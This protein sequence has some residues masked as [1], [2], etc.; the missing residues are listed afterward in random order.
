MIGFCCDK[1]E[2]VDYLWV[3]FV[4]VVNGGCFVVYGVFI[5]ENCFVGMMYVVNDCV[6]NFCLVYFNYV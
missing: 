3:I 5:F 6:I 1:V 4:F 2:D